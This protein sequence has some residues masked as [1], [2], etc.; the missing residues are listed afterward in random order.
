MINHLHVFYTLESLVVPSN[1]YSPLVFIVSAIVL[2]ELDGLKNGHGNTATLA[3][4]AASALLYFLEKR[5][6]LF[7]GQ[8]ADE[9]LFSQFHNQKTLDERIVDCCQYY[10]R[11]GY[12]VGLLTD[13]TILSVMAQ[14]NGT[15]VRAGDP[16]IIDR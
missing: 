9:G 2:R 7:R 3:R 5:P 8:R 13:D 12:Q 16:S 14:A 11:N 6:D 10:Q 15:V 4:K 1:Q